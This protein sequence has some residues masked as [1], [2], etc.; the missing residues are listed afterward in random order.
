MLGLGWL[1]I[2]IGAFA[3]ALAGLRVM[4]PLPGRAGIQPS[5]A[6]SPATAGPLAETIAEMARSH[7]GLTGVVAVP[8]GKDALASRIALT[9]LATRSID[10]Q[11]YIW[12]DDVSGRL[13][14][15]ELYQA[16][17]RGCRVRLL[18]DDNGV[19]GLDGVM[20][21]LEAAPNFEVRIFNPSTTR[22]PKLLGFAYDFL[23]MNRRMHNKSF[24]VD[25]VATIIGGRNIGDEYFHIGDTMLMFDLDVIAVGAVVA[26]IAADF[27]RYWNARSVYPAAK[28]VDPAGADLDGFLAQ[29]A[30]LRSDART[31]DLLRT[32]DDAAHRLVDNRAAIEWT[33]VR[34]YADDPIKG[35]GKAKGRALMVTQL[36]EILGR[37][38]I[39]IDLVSAYFIPGAHGGG[40]FETLARRGVLVRILTNAFSTTD[41][42][43]VHSG[44]I[45]CRKRLLRA[46]VE[47]FE[48]RPGFP[49]AA[50][51]PAGLAGSSS[52]SLHAKMFAIDG[53]DVFIGSFN[54]DPRSAHLNCEM[55]LL[56]ES[57]TLAGQLDATFDTEVPSIA[58]QPQIEADG[59]LGWRDGNAAADA[60]L[61]RPEPDTT[62]IDRA[63][64][65]LI[66]L[67][68][69][70]RWL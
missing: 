63:V 54:F 66:G 52:A 17:L 65:R 6:L 20:A 26:D 34:L 19:A 48:L 53:R 69:I 28:I 45:K 36:A 62:V 31:A 59:G 70:E 56:I 60:P 33:V 44:Y 1:A 43:V 49:G 25:G 24:T 40:V 39:N 27:D 7:P 13:L 67:L 22:R 50:G 64:M 29:A 51:R 4:R 57:P 37:S 42:K 21:T 30:A 11:Y 32:F 38:T 18:L 41:V 16:A 68:P 8:D 12:H 46:G 9:R 5:Y 35:E 47:L 61:K 2:I 55:G 15:H 58:Y 3:A 14:L 10:A 23:R